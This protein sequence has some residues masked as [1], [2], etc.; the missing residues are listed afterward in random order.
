MSIT[1]GSVRD[2]ITN[3]RIAQHI[4]QA[5]GARHGSAQEFR[6]FR[7]KLRTSHQLFDQV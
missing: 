6:D 4:F 3:I 5:L 2:I 7:I 1:Y